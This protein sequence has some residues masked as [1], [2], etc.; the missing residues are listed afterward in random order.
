MSE[1]QRPV[2]ELS[3][4][5][6]AMFSLARLDLAAYGVAVYPG[7]QL[8]PHLALI[9]GRLEAV[10]RGDVRRLV[11][12]LP[13]RFGKSV[14]AAQL[15][16]AWFLGRNPGQHAILAMHGQEIA[17][18]FG[19]VIRNTLT[20]GMHGAI[21]PGCRVASE[22][23]AAHRF[24]LL[25]GG[26]FRAV[27][28]G[29]GIAGYGADLLVLDDLVRDAEEAQSETM[30]RSTWEWLTTGALTRLSP[31]GCAV[32]IGTR[33]NEQDVIG[34]LLAEHGDT[35]E[36]VRLPA[37]AEDSDPLGRE[38]GAPLWP[39]RFSLSDLESMRRQLGSVAFEALYQANPQPPEGRLFKR[40]WFGSLAEPLPRS[41]YIRVALSLDCAAKIGA[42]HDYSAA[43]VIGER[44]DGYDV[45]CA[46]RDRLEYSALRD[47]VLRLCNAWTPD[48]VLIEDASHGTAL[49]QQFSETALPVIGIRPTTSKTNRAMSVLGL[50]ES[51][52][53]RVL[54]GAGWRDDFLAD[55][56]AFPGGRHDD[57]T[58]ALVQG[59]RRLN[60]HPLPGIFIF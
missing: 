47:A 13:P 42:M 3:G 19:R 51:G 30:R 26:S 58:D 4:S 33:W 23:N 52:K 40:E 43:V 56:G 32:L 46:W 1:L 45:L 50:I 55:L 54:E 11:I 10:E 44:E 25:Q 60:D 35:W 2:R 20:G 59:L 36:L 38:P 28:K 34:T 49:I 14:L 53:V 24:A 57:F 48:E 37:L 18:S 8:P 12:C 29:S 9:A 27:G 31:N 16:V 21:F 41:E 17:D 7:F 5:A 39:G 15:F 22:A 6:E